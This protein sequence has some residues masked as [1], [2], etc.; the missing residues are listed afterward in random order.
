M[1]SDDVHIKD[2]D[3]HGMCMKDRSNA[4]ILKLGRSDCTVGSDYY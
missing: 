1:G 2:I 4:S 3:N